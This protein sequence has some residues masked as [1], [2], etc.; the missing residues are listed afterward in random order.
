MALDS[1][2]HH[3]GEHTLCAPSVA[4]GMKN[5]A[6]GRGMFRSRQQGDRDRMA[7][8]GLAVIQGDAQSF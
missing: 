7:D 8:P 6:E 1:V 5:S 4:M 3:D 2:Q